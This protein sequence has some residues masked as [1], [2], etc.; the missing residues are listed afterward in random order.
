MPTNPNR[1]EASDAIA[2]PKSTVSPVTQK[3]S[4]LKVANPQRPMIHWVGDLP[5]LVYCLGGLRP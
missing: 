3:T 1:T 4:K 2:I 5:A